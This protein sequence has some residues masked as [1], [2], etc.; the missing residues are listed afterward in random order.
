MALPSVLIIG[1]QKCGTSMLSSDLSKHPDIFVPPSKEVSQLL[2][3]TVVTKKGINRYQRYYKRSKNASVLI[4]ASTAYTKYP[5]FSGVPKRAQ[6]VL[7]RDVR[8]IY[9]VREPIRRIQSHFAHLFSEGLV[10][11]DINDAIREKEFFLDYSSYFFQ[12]QKWLKDFP[13]E[14]ILIVHFESYVENR[15][16]GVSEVLSFLN[17]NSDE[18]LYSEN[19]VNGMKQRRVVSRPLRAFLRSNA[20]KVFLRPLLPAKARRFFKEVF[21]SPAEVPSLEIRSDTRGWLTECLENDQERFAKLIGLTE[22]SWSPGSWGS[23]T[24]CLNGVRENGEA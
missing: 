18:V 12:I 7:G 6:K 20:F 17:S 10:Q 16:E 14:N 19:V 1:A 2:D 3:D 5:T 24:R 22:M 11:S 4:D 9:I 23:I 21:T 8:I 13:A 15:K